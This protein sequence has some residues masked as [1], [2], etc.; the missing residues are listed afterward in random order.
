MRF[1]EYFVQAVLLAATDE[2]GT[3][4]LQEFFSKHSQYKPIAMENTNA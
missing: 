1:S 4:R 2:E 3:M